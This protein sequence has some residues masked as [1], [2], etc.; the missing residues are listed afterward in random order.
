[1]GENQNITVG[2]STVNSTTVKVGDPVQ[3]ISV[4]ETIAVPAINYKIVAT[5]NTSTADVL[6][7]PIDATSTDFKKNE[8]EEVSDYAKK[9]DKQKEETSDD[10]STDDTET[11]DSSDTKDDEGGSDTKEEDDEKKNKKYEL[12]EQE[13]NDLKDK[14]SALENQYNELVEFKTKIDNQQKDALIAEFYMLSGEDKAEV[15]KNKEKYSLAEIKSMLSVI[16]FDKKVNFGSTVTSAD[17]KSNDETSFLVTTN[18]A[19]ENENLP[20][21]VREVKRT[22]NNL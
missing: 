1:M 3:T 20:E 7:E 14:Y 16:C 13:L 18:F 2:T 8:K 21:W 10:E 12:L 11:E 17:N 9:D 19:N 6:P 5:D 4:G 22:E 15:I